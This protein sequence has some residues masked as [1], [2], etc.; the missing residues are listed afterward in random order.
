[1]NALYKTFVLAPFALF[2][3]CTNSGTAGSTTETENAIARGDGTV[4]IHLNDAARAAYRVLPN[5]FVADTAGTPVPDS[6]YTYIGETDSAGSI[7]IK[8]HLEGSY[9]IEIERG[10]SAIAFQYT[11]DKD[12][13][14]FTIKS[15]KL[16]ARGAVMGSVAVPEN[17]PHAWIHVPGIGRVEKTDSLGNFIIEGLPTGKLTIVSWDVQ[18]QD[19]IAETAVDIPSKDTLDLGHILAPGETINKL[20]MSVKVSD[21]I[22]SW[23][24]PVS[25]PS[26][27]TFRLDSANF[28]FAS[29]K[30]DASD[31]HLL[32]KD[33]NEVPMQI[34][35][36]DSTR[37]SAAIF[38]RIESQKDTS[39]TWTL[40]WG[41]PYAK[42]QEQADV[43]KSVSDSLKYALNTVEI[44]NFDSKAIVNDLPSP[45]K[46]Y[47][48]YVQLHTVDTLSDSVTVKTLSPAS[49]LQ[50]DT[51]GRS[52]TVAHIEYSADYPDY[53]VFGTRVAQ[54][55]HDWG[56][57]DSLVVWLRG[58]GDYE[59]ILENLI[60]SLNYKA[61]HKG[62][63]SSSWE[64]I[65]LKPEDFDY[66][67]RDYHGWEAVRDKITNF[68]IFA[69]N[70]TEIWIDNV[71][72]YG[73]NIDE[74]R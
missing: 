35:F 43:W 74:F 14:A 56:R 42:P 63:L 41:D 39:A 31:V 55:T 11:L 73:I 47:D 37:Q 9:T 28:D 22:S 53:I 52:G 60:D 16:A 61:S 50:A 36:W 5:S 6:A 70:G 13:K 72:A 19:T 32:D 4:T 45:L 65:S 69:Y 8:D 34:D 26:V 25:V 51:K 71:R 33:G 58:D 54:H 18:T 64:R 12:T 48:W 17:A 15:T 30:G 67:L 20:S 46:K 29:A 40:E 10:D 44:F 23:M 1:M 62:K 7:L 59:I 27:I 49:F 24:K 2:C 21:F 57:M 38:V 3:A 68:T 66:V